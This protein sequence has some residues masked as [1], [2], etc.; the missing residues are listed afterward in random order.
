M[1]IYLKVSVIRRRRDGHKAGG[2]PDEGDRRGG[3]GLGITFAAAVGMA[4]GHFEHND[5]QGIRHLNDRLL[6][7]MALNFDP[8][9]YQL[10]L[11]TYIISKVMSKPRFWKQMRQNA[12]WVETRRMVRR[13]EAEARAGHMEDA[14]R[15]LARIFTRIQNAEGR[16]PRYVKS[17]L[18][19]ARLKA[20][21]TFYAQ[22]LSL[23]RAAEMTGLDKREILSYAGQTAMNERLPPTQ[24]VNERM[25]KLRALFG[26]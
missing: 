20:A 1:S 14:Q 7:E 16:D 6:S 10:A 19:K 9:L 8:G 11:L 24:T 25:R 2:V 3:S 26:R 21:S 23:G 22:G 18:A 13:V 15:M 4:A 5:V 12:Y 17:L